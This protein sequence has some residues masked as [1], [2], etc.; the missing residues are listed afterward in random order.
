MVAIRKLISDLLFSSSNAS[1]ECL[2]FIYFLCRSSY[3]V[4]HISKSAGFVLYIASDVPWATVIF[5]HMIFTGGF[6]FKK[7]LHMTHGLK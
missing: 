6:F 5:L 7:I 4:H 2:E 3:N 1:L